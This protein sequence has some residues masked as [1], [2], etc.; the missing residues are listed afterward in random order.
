MR[1]IEFTALTST[2]KGIQA[3]IMTESRQPTSS[4][5]SG[6]GQSNGHNYAQTGDNEASITTRKRSSSSVDLTNSGSDT[7]QL[8][9]AMLLTGCI[10]DDGLGVV[11]WWT[12][13]EEE[14]AT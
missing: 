5:S 4:S 6:G 11:S 12:D 9:P 2:A 7:T 14:G 13:G 3:T 1:K 8:P 10:N